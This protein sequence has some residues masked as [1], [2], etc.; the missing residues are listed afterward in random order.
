MQNPPRARRAT[1][2]VAAAVVL[3]TVALSACTPPRAPDVPKVQRVTTY[4]CD[5]GPMLVVH[6]P[7]QPD[8]P[9]LLEMN[10]RTVPLQPERVVTGFGYGDG[11]TYIRGQGNTMFFQAPR[12]LRVN[13]VA[14]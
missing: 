10:G 6:W 11:G 14:R 2:L 3:S 13:C 1:G 8:G 4:S 12:V 7:A 5:R 9:A